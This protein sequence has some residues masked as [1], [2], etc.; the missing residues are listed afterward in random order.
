MTSLDIETSAGTNEL[1]ESEQRARASADIRRDRSADDAELWERSKAEDQTR[2]KCNVDPISEPQRAHRNRRI[3]R[4]AKDGVD[5]EEHH[6]RDVSG[7]HHSGK[8]RTV[9]DHPW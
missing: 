5:H 7:Q 9:F 2:S 4:A 1:G 6:D 8:C 3:T